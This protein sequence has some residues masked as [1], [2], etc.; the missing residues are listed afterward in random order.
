[1][2]GGGGMS[3]APPKAAWVTRAI[4][5]SSAKSANCAS[6]S[7][8]ERLHRSLKPVPM[9]SSLNSG[10]PMRWTWTN[11]PSLCTGR[12]GARRSMPRR[13]VVP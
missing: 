6:S 11:L 3:N 5:G 13:E 2:R 4:S 1:M 9:I 12:L 7:G 8:S 10:L